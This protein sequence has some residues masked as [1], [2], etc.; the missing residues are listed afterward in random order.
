MIRPM[1]RS[2]LRDTKEIESI[3][4]RE[5]LHLHPVDHHCLS[6]LHKVSYEHD[7]NLHVNHPR[8]TREILRNHAVAD[9]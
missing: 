6:V 3:E 4:I 1:F 2:D 5:F 8:E 9:P 7:S